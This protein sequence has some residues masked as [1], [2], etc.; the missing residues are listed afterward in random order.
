MEEGGNTATVLSNS[1]NEVMGLLNLEKCSQ[2]THSLE[3]LVMNRL[4][5]PKSSAAT[6]EN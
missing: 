1:K 4:P 2:E 3:G 6:E 5:L